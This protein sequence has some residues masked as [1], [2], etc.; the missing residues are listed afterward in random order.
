[1][2][3]PVHWLILIV[4]NWFSLSLIF[5]PLIVVGKI[6][7]LIAGIGPIFHLSYFFPGAS[8]PA[9]FRGF[10]CYIGLN[11]P[12]KDE[13]SYFSLLI[14]FPLSFFLFYQIF[15]WNQ[16][17]S[18]TEQGYFTKPSRKTCKLLFFFSKTNKLKM[19]NYRLRTF[20][21]TQFVI[22]THRFILD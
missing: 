2:C 12:E 19:K 7:S 11:T 14:I 3:H 22:L 21:L 8:I 16:A 10:L 9:C 20:V 6:R 5:L 18:I 15:H 1:M 17:L 13:I 4:C